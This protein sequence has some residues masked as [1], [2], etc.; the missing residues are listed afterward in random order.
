ME[1]P[2]LLSKEYRELLNG[3]YDFA[4]KLVKTATET[5]LSYA[6]RRGRYWSALAILRCVMSS[7]AAAIATLSR[8]TQKYSSLAEVEEDLDEELAATTNSL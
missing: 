5:S 3:V 8:Q 7:P 2:Y 6:Q 4:W 1:E